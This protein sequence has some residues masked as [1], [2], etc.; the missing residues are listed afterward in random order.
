MFDS[1]SIG[2]APKQLSCVDT[3]DP[4]TV[5][6]PIVVKPYLHSIS[7]KQAYVRITLPLKCFVKLVMNGRCKLRSLPDF[8]TDHHR[9]PPSWFS[10]FDHLISVNPLIERNYQDKH[11]GDL[12][13][14]M[15]G[16][17]RFIDRA[18]ASVTVEKRDQRVAKLTRI[19]LDG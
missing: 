10:I 5:M 9:Q 11:S 4:R 12:A 17:R 16:D 18:A 7:E 13:L 14:V 2:V 19:P 15:A 8:A 3:E 6:H 1:H